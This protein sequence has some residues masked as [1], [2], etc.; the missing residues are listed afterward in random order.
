[1]WRQHQPY[2]ILQLVCIYICLHWY[3]FGSSKYNDSST[4]PP[5]LSTIYYIGH[6]GSLCL[7]NGAGFE[8]TT[9]TAGKGECYNLRLRVKSKEESCIGI[10]QENSMEFLSTICLSYIH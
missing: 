7:L 9:L 5:L 8:P 4:N 6:G 2:I 3:Y 1:M 10:T